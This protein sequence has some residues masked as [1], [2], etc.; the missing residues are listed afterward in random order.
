M[1]ERRL[2]GGS[3]LEVSRLSLGSWR[4]FERI[5]PDDGLL[6]MLAAREL[7]I[8]FLDDARYDDETGTAPM[9]TGYSEVRFGELFRQAG[10]RREETIVTNKLWWEF[11]PEQSAAAE[12]DESLARMGFD[13]IDV[14]YA[15]PPPDGLVLEELVRGVTDLVAAG[16][17]RSWA[18]VNWPADLLAEASL[19]ATDMEVPQP[20]AAQL[21][22]SVV[23]QFARRGHRHAGRA[24]SVRGSGRGVVRAGRRGADG[25][26]RR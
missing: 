26:V 25:Q 23:R 13:Y 12:L 14:I 5:S 2:L 18:I 20:C 10:W 9:R 7:G 6:V 24:G 19:I 8:N 1:H 22:Y 17:A 16:V 3:G 4:T 11:W 15:N 21:P